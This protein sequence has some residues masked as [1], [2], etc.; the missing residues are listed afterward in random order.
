VLQA[1]KISVSGR[2]EYSRQEGIDLARRAKARGMT[3]VFYPEW[4]LKGVKGDGARQER[5]YREMA[6]EAD[7]G[8]APVARAWDVALLERPE[9][10]L[11]AGDGN[12]QSALGAFLTACVL[13]GRLTGDSPAALGS[14]PY[15]GADEKDRA[16][17]AGVAARALAE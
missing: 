10:P 2:Y 7:V 13:Y 17:L 14:Y 12:H 9:L 6:Q 15:P 1:Q 5:V 11:H 3:V 8:V 16:F 4:G